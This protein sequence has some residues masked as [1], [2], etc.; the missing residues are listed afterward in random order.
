M[1]RLVLI[2]HGDADG[3]CSASLAYSALSRKYDEI[4]IYFSH[5]AGLYQDIKD[6]TVGGDDILI[7]D[8]AL[9]ERHIND[10]IDLFD[11]LRSQGSKI[12]YIDHH[13]EPLS[14]KVNKMPIKVVHK[15][16]VSASELTFKYFSSFLNKDMSR[17][18]LYG[19]ICDYMDY[20]DWVKRELE[21]WDR[22]MIY[23]EAGVLS[24]GLEGSR[25]M[26]DFKRHIVKHL[27]DGKL[28]SSLSELLVRA[29]I[30]AVS[31]EELRKWI[32][33]NVKVKGEI[34]YVINPPGSIT[35]AAIYARAVADKAIGIAIEKKGNLAIMSLRTNRLDIDLNSILRRICP[36]VNGVG[37]GHKKASGARLP[38][39]NL[40]IFLDKL[41]MAVK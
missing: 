9:S 3:I 7:M 28:P 4:L 34:A 33:S 11:N 29:L 23:F 25:K 36:E 13:P 22:R 39:K 12:T 21:N 5:P 37:G 19:A 31:E 40:D 32:K 15:L 18:A 26:Y 10:L 2:P 38:I 41:N 8:I 20:T 14:T 6:I 17:V 24:Q 16:D 27:A 30:E 35:R 1:E